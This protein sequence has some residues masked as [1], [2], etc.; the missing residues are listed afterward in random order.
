MRVVGLRV[1]RVGMVVV[2]VAVRVV[3]MM[4]VIHVQTAGSGA[5]VIAQ[6]AG[7]DRRARCIRTLA[8]NVVVVAFL[9]HALFGFEA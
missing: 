9:R 1:F 6:I 2:I 3:V 4:V 5:E 8:F 7:F